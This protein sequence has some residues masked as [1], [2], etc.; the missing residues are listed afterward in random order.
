MINSLELNDY[1]L[2]NKIGSVSFGDVYTVKEKKT[3]NIY[4]AKIAKEVLEDKTIKDVRE[5][6]REIGIL[7]KA[8]HLSVLK[9]IY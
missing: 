6:M 7:S 9:F 2:Q 1:V 3:G 5:F 4:A 8:N